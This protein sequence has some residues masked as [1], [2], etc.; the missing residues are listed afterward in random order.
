MESQVTTSR[1]FVL[2]RRSVSLPP[3]LGCLAM[4]PRS[5]GSD[6]RTRADRRL[7]RRLRAVAS[8]RSAERSVFSVAA[9][10]PAMLRATLSV[11]AAACLILR[12]ISFAAAFC[13]ADPFNRGK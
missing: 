3:D 6:P 10:V 5:I 11:R 9:A 12:D 2:P 4:P 1:C 7:I 8:T 13:L